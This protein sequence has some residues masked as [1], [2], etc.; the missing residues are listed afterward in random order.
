MCFVCTGKTKL[1]GFAQSDRVLVTSLTILVMRQLSFRNF[2]DGQFRLDTFVWTCSFFL[3]S[4]L[5][6]N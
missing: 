3:E 6:P 1:I 2:S 5:L 4:K